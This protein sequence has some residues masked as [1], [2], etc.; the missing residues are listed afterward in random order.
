MV[1]SYARYE[2]GSCFGV[3]SSGANIVYVPQPNQSSSASGKVIT[4]GLEEILIWN[5][6][7]GEL[8]QKLRDTVDPGS[9]NAKTLSSPATVSALQYH[10]QANIIAAGYSDGTIKV[11]DIASSSVVIVFTGHKSAITQLF[12]DRLGTRLVSGGKDAMII[13]WDLVAEVGLFKLKGHKDQITSLKLVSEKKAGQDDEE[14][15]MDDIDSME[16]WLIST[17]KDGLIKLWDLKAKISVETHVAH[18]GEC[19]SF[20]YDPHTQVLITAGM[21]NQLKVWYVDLS[22]PTTKLIEKGIYLKQ[23]NTR[24]LSVQFKFVNR[25]LVFFMCQNADKT[26]EVFRIRN[27]EEINKAIQRKVKKLKEKGTLSED[28]I[29]EQ[30]E[31]GKINMLVH[32]ITTIRNSSK[33]KTC[34]WA[35][36]ST[37]LIDIIV[38]GNN[39]SVEYYHVSLPSQVKKISA[40][41]ATEIQPIKK[42]SL[43]LLGHRTDVRAID[44]SHDNKLLASASNGQLKI[45]N[46]RTKNCLRTIDIGYALC[47]KFLPG[48]GLVIVGT[49]TGG[50]QLFELASSELI[51]EID[52]AHDNSIW[53]LDITTDGKTLITGS[54]D[55]KIKY[56]HFKVEQEIVPGTLKTTVAKMRLSHFKTL[57]LDEDI[58]CVKLSQDSQNKFLAVSLLDNT[59]K[60][61]HF[62]TLKFYLSLYGH[63]LPVLAID[64]SFDNK[65]VVTSSAD[66]NIKI[67]G[68]DFGD[69]HKSIFAH[70]DSIMNVAFLP[71]SHNFFSAAKD[72]MVKYWDGDKFECVQKL[73]AHQ[74]EVWAMAIAKHTGEFVITASHDHSLRVWQETSDEVFLEEEKEKEIDELYENTLLD[75][76]EQDDVVAERIKKG[77]NGGGDEEEAN[78]EVEGVNKQTTESLKDGE[79]LMEA[80]DIGS[81]DLDDQLEYQKQVKTAANPGDVVKPDR[82]IILVAKNISAPDYVFQT[83]TAIKAAHLEDALLVLPFS[84]SVKLLRF[85]TIWTSEKKYLLANLSLICKLLFFV[86]RIH[87]K[88]I[89]YSKDPT[90]VNTSKNGKTTTGYSS[91]TLKAQLLQ[92]KEKLRAEMR[93]I[94]DEYLGYNI[95]GLKFVRNQ[96]KMKHSK[97]FV[98]E[99]AQAASE[100]KSAPKRAFEKVI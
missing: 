89:V 81:K 32:P 25:N 22:N 44:I 38:S 23:S 4:A 98:D 31:L 61:F 10:E 54:A 18:S 30:V 74:S 49:R 58:L 56:W 15:E 63:K 92:V 87:H 37:K 73:A 11:W 43:D 42:H 75:Q 46:I 55:K 34:S 80:L 33:I 36:A 17:S 70:Q 13:M 51:C 85:L 91:A 28:E 86:V 5:I 45:W 21:E 29:N 16:D 100:L 9:I 95:E 27:A 72:G 65:L 59:V 8:L 83:V 71:Q 48:D 88:E 1:K 53:S 99:F 20:D 93:A 96:W 26:I 97:E 6:K 62:D 41:N 84:Y 68:L 7:T 94:E 64:I 52:Q 40:T 67:W 3:I 39:N 19:W 69:C 2:H 66:K 82:N 35:Q 76:L 50:L 90:T 12:F 60:I 77:V 79:K 78:D 57:E 14:Q 47:C 24:G